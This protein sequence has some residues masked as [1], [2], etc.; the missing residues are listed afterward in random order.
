MVHLALVYAGLL[1]GLAG[2]APP[3]SQDLQ[4]YEA[5]ERKAGDGPQAQVKL[6]LWCEAHGLNTER[7]KHLGQ[8]ILADPKNATAHG[9]M[10]QVASGDR[11]ESPDQIAERLRADD[12]RAARLADYNGRRAVLVEKERTNRAFL[13]SMIKDDARPESVKE[14]GWPVHL[15]V[16]RTKFKMNRELALAH[17]NLGTW[18]EQNG[19]KGEAIAHFT[20]A[21]H[22]DP[23]RE[24]SWRH[25]G[26]VKHNGR[27]ISAE[28]AAA[29]EKE[30]HAQRLAGRH[31]EPLLHKWK[32]W[33]SGSSSH[34]EL[35]EEHLA[36]VTDPHA[37]PSILKVFPIGGSEADQS[38]LVAMLEKIDD[39]RSSRALAEL[40]V[41][42]RFLPVRTAAMEALKKRPPRD[43]VGRWSTGSTP[44]SAIRS[45]PWRVRA[46]R[47]P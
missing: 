17:A 40:A 34:R 46:R 18:C 12:Q 25:L 14:K 39:P 43:Y 26:Y 3:S 36:T 32:G 1:A 47:A 37:V 24:A 38:R 15:Q 30:E 28:E 11:W 27:W 21:V 41:S 16:A 22:L 10:G 44:S 5:L 4:T 29:S 6:S 45:S 8:A 31:W 23:S 13:D 35:A 20:T 9:L 33:L 42:T 2:D 19:L 7:L